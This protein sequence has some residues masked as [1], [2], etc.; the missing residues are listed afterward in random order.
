MFLLYMYEYGCMDVL[1]AVWHCIGIHSRI[2]QF[3][4][5]FC[6]RNMRLV[7]ALFCGASAV[8]VCCPAQ[9]QS[10]FNIQQQKGGIAHVVDDRPA[11]AYSKSS[12]SLLLHAV[13]TFT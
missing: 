7:F 1:L 5:K 11:R 4:R 10:A 12:Y 2:L 13:S 8:V 9:Q 6:K 3:C